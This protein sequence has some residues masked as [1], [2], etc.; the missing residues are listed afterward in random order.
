MIL[1]TA[2]LGFVLWL[3]A[4]AIF[5]FWGHLFFTPDPQGHMIMFT[6]CVFVCA[7]IA[8]FALRWLAKDAA[9][10]A[11]AAIGLAFP[12]MF[13]DAFVVQNFQTVFP[14][15]DPLLG[16]TF[17]AL[18]LLGYG[19]IIFTGLLMTQISAQDEQI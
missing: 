9:D 16:Q 8:F 11:E 4:T 5:Y 13:L 1:K 10:R 15:I 14:Q 18:M 12:G 6:A 2:G 17:G 3:A 7:A 19:A